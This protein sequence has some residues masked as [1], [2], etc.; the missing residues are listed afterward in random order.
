MCR[1][2]LNILTL[3]G[4]YSIIMN[5][6]KQILITILLFF[7]LCYITDG[8]YPI[9]PFSI[10][11]EGPINFFLLIHYCFFSWLNVRFYQFYYF[12][13]FVITIW[14]YS[15]SYQCYKR[16][17]IC[18]S[19]IIEVWNAHFLMFLFILIFFLTTGFNPRH[20]CFFFSLSKSLTPI[21]SLFNAYI[22]L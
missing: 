13:L 12:V 8:F 9:L 2:H 16:K 22:L 20:V 4:Q 1:H 5:V 6:I 11:H 19:Q 10:T 15:Q 14:L 7:K 21:L 18:S 17:F 3:W